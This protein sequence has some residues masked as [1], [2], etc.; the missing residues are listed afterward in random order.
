MSNLEII[1]KREE[2]QK[3]YKYGKSV[4]GKSVV[5]YFLE[6]GVG[7]CRFGFS[8][9]KKL[10]KAVTR[11]RVRRILKE[12][13]R[14]RKDLF[15]PGKDYIIVARRGVLGLKYQQV[16]KDVAELLRKVKW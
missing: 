1:K 5:I 2:F 10:G 8:V 6:N 13:C 11:N 14:L 9:S 12:V 4:A 7:Y 3:V 16:E 15:P